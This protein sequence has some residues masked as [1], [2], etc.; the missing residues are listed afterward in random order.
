[1]WMRLAANADV[2]FV[3]GVDQ[4]YH[5]VHGKN[6]ITSY[7]A[8]TDLRQRRLAYEAILDR[9]GDRL[10]DAPRLS[11]IMYR[12][13]GREALWAAARAYDRGEARKA[14]VDELVAFALDCS[15]EVRKLPVY[16]TLRLRRLIGPDV[17]PYLQ[18]VIWSAFGSKAAWYL[19]RRSWKWR[20]Y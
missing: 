10:T 1:M 2:G 4:A 14:P 8:L 19:R 5:R 18:P 7:N 17:M 16:R 20:G 6:M 15:P 11:R 13:L 9:Y 3:R 12:K